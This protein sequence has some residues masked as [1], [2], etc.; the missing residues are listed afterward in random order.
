MIDFS[1]FFV[2]IRTFITVNIEAKFITAFFVVQFL[3][4]IFLRDICFSF[5]LWGRKIHLILV[6]FGKFIPTPD[7]KHNLQ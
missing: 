1:L 7:D 4:F 6:E 3:C 2:G 5:D